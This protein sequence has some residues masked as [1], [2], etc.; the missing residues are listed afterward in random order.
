MPSSCA[1]TSPVPWPRE[2]APKA[3]KELSI[4]L[5]YNT[6]TLKKDDLLSCEVTLRYNREGKANMTIVDLGL[7][8]G[9]ELLPDAFETLRTRGVIERYS[10][11]GR[12][13]ILYFRELQGG[14]PVV[15]THRLRAKFPVKAKTPRSVVYQYYEP[16]LRDTAA[17]VELNVL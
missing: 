5:A 2:E 8:P 7:P 10:V 12:Q 13:V 1:A 3:E 17:P 15:F 4:G 6:T 11:T 14:Q 9:F 16:A